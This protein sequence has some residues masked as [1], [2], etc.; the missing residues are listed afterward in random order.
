MQGL[1]GGNAGP[2]WP[3]E[4]SL[5]AGLLGNDVT[6][7]AVL[8]TVSG[9]VIAADGRGRW[10][11]ESTVDEVTRKQESDSEQ[12]IFRATFKERE[13]GFALTGVVYNKGKTFNLIEEARRI[14]DSL[15]DSKVN[16]LYDYIDDFLTH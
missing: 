15:A 14:A 3:P 8:Y 12:K 4:S 7:I 2:I 1:F 10:D 6:A 13:I 11:D 16:S 5:L 9:F